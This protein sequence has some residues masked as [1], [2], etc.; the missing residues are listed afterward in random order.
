[1]QITLTRPEAVY[2][3]ST[4]RHMLSQADANP[5]SIGHLGYRAP[6][7]EMLE[8][9]EAHPGELAFTRGQANAMLFILDAVTFD[10][11]SE[12][13]P[14]SELLPVIGDDIRVKFSKALEADPPEEE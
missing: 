7:A 6:V 2:L 5:G 9:L 13:D 14:I 3:R 10:G 12:S 1:M 11:V 8:A 4:F